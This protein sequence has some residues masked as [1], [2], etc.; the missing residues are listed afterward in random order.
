VSGKERELTVT[1]SEQSEL[2]RFISVKLREM[3]LPDKL[4]VHLHTSLA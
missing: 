4:N 3:K 1:S 2:G